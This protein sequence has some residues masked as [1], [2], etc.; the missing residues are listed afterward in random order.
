MIKWAGGLLV[1]FGAAHL[2]LS[3]ALAG[4][5]HIGSWLSGALWLPDGGFAEMSPVVAGFWFTTGSFGL[6]LLVVGLTVLWMDRHGIVPPS[7]IAWTIGAWSLIGGLMLEPAPWIGV[8]IGVGLLLAGTKKA[9]RR[10]SEAAAV[11]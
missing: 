10:Q 9:A 6:P 3:F 1:F 8:W 4:P 2:L 5:T 11:A 7:F